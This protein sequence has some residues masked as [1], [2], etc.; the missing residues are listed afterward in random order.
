MPLCSVPFQSFS[1]VADQ[2]QY[3][4][5]ISWADDRFASQFLI[6]GDRIYGSFSA[7]SVGGIRKIWT[8]PQKVYLL[9]NKPLTKV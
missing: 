3:D 1:T 8:D 4:V 9:I 6:Q 5:M 2:K 7:G